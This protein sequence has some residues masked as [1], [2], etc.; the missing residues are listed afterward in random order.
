[1]QPLVCKAVVLKVRKIYVHEP[2]SRN[3]SVNESRYWWHCKGKGEGRLNVALD[4]GHY[5]LFLA[6]C[7]KDNCPCSWQRWAVCSYWNDKVAMYSVEEKLSSKQF[8]KRRQMRNHS[9]T[10]V[11]ISGPDPTTIYDGQKRLYH[12]YYYYAPVVLIPLT[13]W[14]IKDRLMEFLSSS[15]S[16][17]SA[18]FI[19]PLGHYERNNL[20]PESIQYL[21]A[22]QAS[23]LPQRRSSMASP[24]SSLRRDRMSI[25]VRPTD[26]KPLSGWAEL[27][28]MHSRPTLCAVNDMTG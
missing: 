14:T 5:R 26:E 12:Y 27:A 15:S 20:C 1:M 4:Q 18:A 3:A 13:K 6:V 8:S 22:N 19:T 21:A 9:C 10:R 25:T 28:L 17:S 23:S 7:N 24:V 16:S 11:Q 2:L